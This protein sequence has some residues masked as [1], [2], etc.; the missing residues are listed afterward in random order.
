MTQEKIKS[1][2][3][4]LPGQVLGV[5]EEYIPEKGSAY[6]L[7]GTI[8]A[9]KVGF[10]DIN[11]RTRGIRIKGEPEPNQL[12]RGDQVIGFIRRIRKYSVGLDLYKRNDQ[13]LFSPIEANIHVSRVSR[14]YVQKLEDAFQETDIVRARVIGKRGGEFELSTEAN[15][16]GVVYADC[17]VCGNT[18]RRKDRLLICDHCGNREKRLLANDYGRV[19]EKVSI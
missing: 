10:I 14:Q 9:A 2:D 6:E 4:V 17:S 16:L 5:I 8:Y 7:D 18:L 11:P 15:Y 3:F 19:K 13:I 12:K 1:G